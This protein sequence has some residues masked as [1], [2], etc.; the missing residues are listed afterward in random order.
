MPPLRHLFHLQLSKGFITSLCF[1]WSNFSTAFKCSGSSPTQ[2]YIWHRVRFLV[3]WFFCVFKEVFQTFG[4][5]SF[6][7]CETW[8][9]NCN[10]RWYVT[11]DEK[12]DL[13]E[14]SSKSVA[15]FLSED[16]FGERAVIDWEW[17]LAERGRV[18]EQG[19]Y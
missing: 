14:G 19:F 6:P 11:E 8:E 5:T 4:Q 9:C 12:N 13:G 16:N 7:T 18:K 15:F 2:I 1:S 3:L 17:T 10:F